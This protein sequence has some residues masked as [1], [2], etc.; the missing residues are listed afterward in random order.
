MFT[1]FSPEEVEMDGDQLHRRIFVEDFG[2]W[3]FLWTNLGSAPRMKLEA[4]RFS[5]GRDV[6]LVCFVVFVEV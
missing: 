6:D 2:S 3:Q 1:M 4:R 5:Y